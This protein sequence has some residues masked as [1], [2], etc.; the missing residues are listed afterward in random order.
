M[1]NTDLMPQEECIP[2]ENAT[3]NTVLIEAAEKVAAEEVA[4]EEEVVAEKVAAEEVVAE[5]VAAEA[6]D[7]SST[8]DKAFDSLNVFVEVF[9]GAFVE[10]ENLKEATKV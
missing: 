3:D 6:Q 1:E 5:E 8:I 10:L 4:A 7:S 2:T 9:Q